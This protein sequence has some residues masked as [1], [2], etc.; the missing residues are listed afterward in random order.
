MGK[1][2]FCEIAFLHEGVPDV[3]L[4]GYDP[5]SHFRIDKSARMMELRPPA[6][7]RGLSRFVHYDGLTSLGII[8]TYRPIGRTISSL[9]GIHPRVD[10]IRR[11][12]VA[13]EYS[14]PEIRTEVG[15]EGTVTVSVAGRSVTVEP[16]STGELRLEPVTVEYHREGPRIEVEG[17][18][19]R[20]VT[21]RKA[22]VD[23]TELVPRVE[24]VNHG[25]LDV[26]R[27]TEVL[28]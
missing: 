28:E 17:R 19:G 22:V 11:L 14:R 3:P 25:K 20:R 16:G 18:D 8:P 5:M 24:V 27:P 7:Q 2:L 23:S 13:S 21:T 12:Q 15:S 10:G 4:L 1:R 6:G 26:I 9:D